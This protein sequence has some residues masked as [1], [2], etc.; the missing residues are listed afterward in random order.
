MDM[1]LKG[2]QEVLDDFP[3][4]SHGHCLARM[5]V[6]LDAIKVMAVSDGWAP[7]CADDVCNRLQARIDAAEAED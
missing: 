1:S 5:S 6:I 4:P 7:T 3:L 2:A